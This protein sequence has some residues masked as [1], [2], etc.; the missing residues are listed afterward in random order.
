MWGDNLEPRLPLHDRDTFQGVVAADL[1]RENDLARALWLGSLLNDEGVVGDI[2]RM[3][4][5]ERCFCEVYGDKFT[6]DDYVRSVLG[7]TRIMLLE[8]HASAR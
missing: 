5:K 8:R 6:T 1:Q 7:H 3:V 2:R 4:E